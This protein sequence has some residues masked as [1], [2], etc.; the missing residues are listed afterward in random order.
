LVPRIEEFSFFLLSDSPNFGRI[1]ME[2]VDQRGRQCPVYPSGRDYKLLLYSSDGSC[3]EVPVDGLGSLTVFHL[4]G[5]L[6]G[7]VTRAEGLNSETAYVVIHRDPL[8]Q[9]RPPEVQVRHFSNADTWQACIIR[10]PAAVSVAARDWA[11]KALN[12]RIRDT[13]A[14][15]SLLWPA[16]AEQGADR[17][18]L[19]PSSTELLVG[20]VRFPTAEI[21]SARLLHADESAPS[22]ISLH[23]EQALL[24]LERLRVGYHELQFPSA[25]SPTINI[26]VTSSIQRFRSESLAFEFMQEGKLQTE[27]LWSKSL[28]AALERIAAG[29]AQLRATRVPKRCQIAFKSWI[30]GNHNSTEFR[31]VDVQAEG[32]LITSAILTHLRTRNSRFELDAGGFGKIIYPGEPKKSPPVQRVITNNR[33]RWLRL[34]GVNLGER[35]ALHSETTED[36]RAHA[37]Q[38]EQLS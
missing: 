38:L 31:G 24:R 6:G 29:K 10:F 9:G 32:E 30:N 18:W 16:N 28:Y 12:L 14:S 5:T 1:A 3:E 37:R 25:L 8:K 13:E 7:R 20:A 11:S 19:V 17:R 2:A 4:S 21:N 27:T 23:A 33:K 36:L 15:S 35:F 22:E 26:L 34:V